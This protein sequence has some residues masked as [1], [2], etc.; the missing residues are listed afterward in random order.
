MNI[1]TSI[2]REKLAAIAA[3]AIAKL[4]P[5]NA[6][7]RRWIRAIGRAVAEVENNPFLTWQPDSR[8]LLILSESGRIYTANGTCECKA[9]EQKQPCYHRALSRLILRYIEAVH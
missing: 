1:N 8:S 3:E 9:F 2:D 4:N 5:E 6:A 7:D